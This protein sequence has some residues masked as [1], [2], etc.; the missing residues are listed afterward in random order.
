MKGR[1]MDPVPINYALHTRGVAVTEIHVRAPI[2]SGK[3]ISHKPIQWMLQC[4][5]VARDPNQKINGPFLSA[6]SVRLRPRRSFGRG[7]SCL[8]AKLVHRALQAFI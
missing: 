3:R 1:K 6:T 2:P 5:R 8:A 7:G 4:R